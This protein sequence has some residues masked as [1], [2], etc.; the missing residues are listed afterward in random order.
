MGAPTEPQAVVSHAEPYPAQQS[1]VHRPP[2][3]R[4]SLR[5]TQQESQI[6]FSTL[7]ERYGKQPAILQQMEAFI[8]SVYERGPDSEGRYTIRE[9]L[10]PDQ[11]WT[12][13]HIPPAVEPPPVAQKAAS[14]PSTSSQSVTSRKI[15]PAPPMTG[16]N[17]QAQVIPP[18]E[19][20]SNAD[21][22][23]ET[24]PYVSA[25]P[26]PTLPPPNPSAPLPKLPPPQAEASSTSVRF[27]PPITPRRLAKPTGVKATASPHDIARDLL[28]AFGKSLKRKREEEGSPIKRDV[29]SRPKSPVPVP[30]PPPAPEPV[31]TV[32]SP[33]SIPSV[34]PQAPTESRTTGAAPSTTAANPASAAYL[35]VLEQG[36]PPPKQPPVSDPRP[37]PEP[38]LKTPVA[39]I[40]SSG[41]TKPVLKDASDAV[42]IA[43][44]PLP[45]SSVPVQA[46]K[47]PTPP[48][49]SPSP[50]IVEIPATPSVRRPV[51]EAVFLTPS[52]PPAKKPLF[53]ASSPE[54]ALRTPRRPSIATLEDDVE[55][56]EEWPSSGNDVPSAAPTVRQTSES[57]T[58]AEIDELMDE[59]EEIR[60]DALLSVDSD[61]RTQALPLSPGRQ[62]FSEPPV[63]KRFWI[64]KPGM[65]VFVEVPSRP[66][67]V[68]AA[69]ALEEARR[70][71]RQRRKENQARAQVDG[72]NTDNTPPPLPH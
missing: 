4:S 34:L 52:G 44:E 47:L 36:A 56:M 19:S 22:T 3:G 8:A 66:D 61:V 65:Q 1:D 27:V 2:L 72:T 35:V 62:A 64:P 42:V 57:H 45:S 6:Y 29:P 28:R 51:A 63:T 67:L 26:P 17:L 18:K 23:K 41:S 32:A 13:V 24:P 55:I 50:E 37:P 46:P 10:G 33:P 40:E 9:T 30:A 54:V 69:H 15:Q 43:P 71:Q 60:V 12:L 31:T 38:V 25:T 70:A 39:H 5:L 48:P 59:S 58:D 20:Q 16:P 11:Q 7:R 49:R 53:L 14:V 68:A 21:V